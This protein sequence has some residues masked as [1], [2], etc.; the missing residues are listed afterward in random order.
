MLNAIILFSLRNRLLVL[1][2]A[3]AVVVYG[4]IQLRQMPV[5][6]FPDLNRPTVTIM[7]EAAGLAPEEVEVLVTRPIEFLL[8]GATGVQR[9][10]SSSGI[11]LSIVWVEFDWGTDIFQDR[12]IVAEK[13]QLARERLPQDANPVMAPISSIMGEI[14][15]LG[16]RSTATASDEAAAATK[17]MELRTLAEFT[18]RN[19]LLA[20]EG[21]SQVTVMGGVLKQYQIVTSPARLAAQGVTLEQLT[22]AAQ[23]ANVLAS[24]GIV[25]RPPKESLL[26]VS[27]QSLTLEDVASTPV[28]WREPIPVLIRDVAD[29]QFGGPI[30]RG[31]GSVWVKVAPEGKE[32]RDAVQRELPAAADHE[33]GEHAHHHDEPAPAALSGGPAVILTVQ[34]QPNADTLVLDRKID[35]M[36]D[37]LQKD[38]PGDIQIERR[39]FRQADFIEAAVD[40]VTEAVRDGAIW[41]VVVLFFFM[42]NFRTS[43]SSLTSMPLSILLTILVFHWFNITINTMTL[44][45]IAVAIGDLVDDS[46]VDIENIYRRLK[47]NRRLPAPEQRPALTVIYEASTEIRN[48]IVYATLIVILVVFPL[49]SMS[50]LEGRMF[51]PLGIS[52]IIALLCSLVVS[53]TF[54]PVLGS[55]LLPGAKFLEEERDPLLMRWLKAV[56]TVVLR[57]TLR[58]A[59]LI[60]GVM[61]VLVVI[62]CA[63]IFW[64]GGEFLPPFNEGT[65]TIN[66]RMEPGTSLGESERIATQAERSILDVSEVL[67]VSRRTGR[68]EL[69]EH[70]EGVNSSELDVALA[71]YSVPREGKLYGV[72][73]LIPVAHL[74]GYQTQ[75]RPREQVIADIRDRIA[76]IPGAAVNIGQPI[77]HR[78]DHMMSGIRAQIAVKVFGQDLRE[79]RTAAYD[80]QE[81]MQPIAGIVDLQIEPQ[82]EISQIRLKINREEAAR[83]GLTPGDIAELAETAYKGR[84]V[85][86]ILDEDRYFDLVVWYDAA[87][88]SDPE[89]I[90]QT[91]IDSPSGRRI[92][93]DQ[94][95]EI[96]DTTG[97]NTLNREHVQRRIVVFCNV[98]GRDLA[99]VV[100]DIRKA[101]APV[102]SKLTAAPGSYYVE[103]SGQ[104]EAQ[105]D[106]Q[107]RLLILGALSIVGVF[108]LL[109]KA[110]ESWRAALQVMANIPLAA[111]GSVVTLLLVNRPAWDTLKAAPLSQWPELWIGATSLSVAHWVGF[112]TLIGVV[113]RNGIMMISHY[114][115]LMQHEGET[116]S[117]EM[118]IRGSLERLAPVMMTATTSFIGLLP[119]LFGAGQTGKEI[120]YPLALVVFGGMLTSTLLDQIVTPALFFKFGR[121]VY[122][123][124]SPATR[125]SPNNHEGGLATIAKV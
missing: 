10:R 21:V 119:L 73:R 106:A 2:A 93:L 96:L 103:I 74:W 87:S 5:D 118:I 125:Q 89:V 8:N 92:A 4:V 64:M 17:A 58:H 67:S 65:L 29:V 28:L 54:T 99:S 108:L 38:L 79:L 102:E 101:I 110:L 48:S 112:I 85:S 3:A 19:R 57:Y 105:Q 59:T 116:F 31:N 107:R 39:I 114:I 16:V 70:A 14:M 122:T 6:V 51:A 25:V 36:L 97:P 32:A 15:L 100:G 30:A 63:S 23:Q 121:K 104:F 111:F 22:D 49:F 69:D 95:A 98:Q 26:R 83:H 75:G 84:V 120:L 56:D 60:L 52:Y 80:I 113:S 90:N 7:T 18:L 71:E 62:A 88:R 47:E 37:Q 68:A 86:Q 27:G 124:S 91:V 123:H 76:N 35:A 61:S 41:V 34:K 43:V 45:G 78:L 117:E 12:Q 13:L 72:L 46:I 66:V 40:N 9:V 44:G 77:S 115:H 82:V 50:G 81:R 55:L 1:I 109:A 24:G 53:L 94:V 42:G 33:H 20:V 11:G